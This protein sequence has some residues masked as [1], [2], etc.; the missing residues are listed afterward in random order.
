MRAPVYTG[1]S[2]W[3]DLQRQKRQDELADAA[4]NMTLLSAFFPMGGQYPI[5]Y[6]TLKLS[7]AEDK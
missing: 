7:S 6:Q 4:K 2:H 3:S 5:T 1:D